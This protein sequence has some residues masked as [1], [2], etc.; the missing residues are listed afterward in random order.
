[1]SPRVAH[2]SV[3]KPGFRC[4]RPAPCSGSRCREGWGRP[5]RVASWGL[6]CPHTLRSG[7]VVRNSSSLVCLRRCQVSH[8]KDECLRGSFVSPHEFDPRKARGS[9]AS[10]PGFCILRTQ[11]R[12]W[13]TRHQVLWGATV[14]AMPLPALPAV[15]GPTSSPAPLAVGGASIC[16]P[17]PPSNAGAPTSVVARPPGVSTRCAG[18]CFVHCGG[19]TQLQDR[20]VWPERPVRGAVRTEGLSVRRSGISATSG[21]KGPRTGARLCPHSCQ[22]GVAA[23][24]GRQAAGRAAWAS[25]RPRGQA[26][27]G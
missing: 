15:G 14:S 20:G 4:R 17:L 23:G 27:R 13:G 25:G 9:L 2:E 21:T 5:P 11:G 16:T 6:R 7:P 1:M 22:A 12:V 26:E 3:T 10:I 19:Q 24:P 8:M 18:S